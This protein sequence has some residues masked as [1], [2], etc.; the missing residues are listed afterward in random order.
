MP[1]AW[2]RYLE[3]IA[4]VLLDFTAK[5]TGEDLPIPMPSNA[6]TKSMYWELT[7]ISLVNL[8]SPTPS[9]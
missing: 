9:S 4:L 3:H 6:R 2:R 5:V 1:Y 7:L 8:T